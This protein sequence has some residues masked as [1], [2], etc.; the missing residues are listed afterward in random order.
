MPISDLEAVM[1]PPIATSVIE[2]TAWV[3]VERSL[4][5]SLPSDYKDFIRTY[6]LGQ[7]ADFLC[8]LTPFSDNPNVNLSLQIEQQLSALRELHAAGESAPYPLFPA[9]GGIM[10]FAITD[11]GD[12]LHWET[13]GAPDAWRVVV[14]DARSPMYEVYNAGMTTFLAGL[15]S[16]DFSSSILPRGLTPE[17]RAFIA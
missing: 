17:F 7:V 2:P 16:P 10:P 15:F 9:T 4:G 12:V 13:N 3:E 5:T 11:N 8:V 14:N 6:G 1:P